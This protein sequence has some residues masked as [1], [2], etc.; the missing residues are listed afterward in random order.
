MPDVCSKAAKN[1]NTIASDHRSGSAPAIVFV[2]GNSSSRALWKPLMDQMGDHELLAIDLRGHGDSE[3]VRPPNYSTAG[4]AYDIAHAVQQLAA[5]DFILVGHSN[6]ALASAYFAAR[7]E[8]KPKACVYIDIAPRVPEHQVAYF[9]ERASSVD[10]VWTS[11]DKLT[12][13]MSAADPSIPKEVLSAYLS[14]FSEPVEGGIR[15]K[16]DPMTYGAWEP[17]DVWNDLATLTMPLHI[18]RGGNSRVLSAE[19]ASAMCSRIP[20][21]RYYEVE[22][23]GHFMMLAK[24]ESLETITRNLIVEAGFSSG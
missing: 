22:G 19:V 2:H 20:T 8:P 7:L 10:R 17:E 24:P 11:L 16:L 4:Y 9:R 21:A 14:A 6:G 5:R 13:A 18:V 15:Q 1:M 12:S 23:A 3:W